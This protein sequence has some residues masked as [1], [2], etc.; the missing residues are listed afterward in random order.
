MQRL[1]LPPVRVRLAFRACCVAP[2][3][4]RRGMHF[5][6]DRK[7]AGLHLI[8]GLFTAVQAWLRLKAAAAAWGAYG[9]GET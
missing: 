8:T 9:K 7:T 3:A 4:K 1:R 2:V 5:I 6:R